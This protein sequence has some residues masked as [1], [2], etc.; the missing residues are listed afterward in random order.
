MVDRL[1]CLHI[2]L[3]Y[4]RHSKYRLNTHKY[5]D[6]STES[7]ILYNYETIDQPKSLTSEVRIEPFGVIAGD[8]RDVEKAQSFKNFEPKVDSREGIREPCSM[9]SRVGLQRLLGVIQNLR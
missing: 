2:P 8:Q 9:R 3:G 4:K 7:K 6:G 5:A 1:K